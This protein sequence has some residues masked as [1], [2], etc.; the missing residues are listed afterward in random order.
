[1]AARAVGVLDHIEKI[2]EL[3]LDGVAADLARRRG[4]ER[5]AR[6]RA[7]ARACRAS[8]RWPGA[9]RAGRRLPRAQPRSG[10]GVSD[11]LELT[12]AQAAGGDRAPATLDAARAVRGLPRARAAADDLNAFT[13]VADEAPATPGDAPLAGVPARGQGPVLHRGRAQ[14]GRLAHPRGL[15]PAVH[16]PP[17][18]GSC[19]TAGAPLLGKTNQ[20]EFAMGS[21]QRELRLRP[22]PATRGTARACPAAR[23]A[24]A[25]RRSRPASRP[26]R[27][28]PTPAA[29]SASP[30]RCAGSSG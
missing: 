24:A 20:D 5:A 28:A 10:P 27:S 3:D 11:P 18:C 6:G 7:R 17:S 16:A 29:R 13:W 22:G 25:P 4:R 1:M 12:A 30:R 26:G 14:P 9:G 2:S 8:W 19:T 21:S 23:A 15:P